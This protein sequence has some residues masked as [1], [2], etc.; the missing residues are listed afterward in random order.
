MPVIISDATG[1]IPKVMG[2]A[3]RLKKKFEGLRV[4]MASS[5]ESPAKMQHLMNIVFHQDYNELERE[6]FF[7]GNFMSVDDPKRE[8][9][10]PEAISNDWKYKNRR[11]SYLRIAQFLQV[12]PEMIVFID[13]DNFNRD[14]AKEAG[15]RVFDP[16]N[17]ENLEAA[18]TE[19]SANP[20][21]YDAGRVNRRIV[22]FTKPPSNHIAVLV[23]NQHT[24]DRQSVSDMIRDLASD[25][26]NADVRFYFT[27]ST[28]DNDIKP[29]LAA[30]LMEPEVFHDN[31]IVSGNMLSI[32]GTVT[33]ED[34]YGDPQSRIYPLN[35]NYK[36]N[37]D[38]RMDEEFYLHLSNQL[39]T[40]RIVLLDD[41]ADNLQAAA[42]AGFLG[43]DS[44]HPESLQPVIEALRNEDSRVYNYQ[45][46][47][48][49][50]QE[51]AKRRYKEQHPDMFTRMGR[52]MR[53][54]LGLNKREP[55]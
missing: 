36:A 29:D 12:A 53:N 6:G 5:A 20:V 14:P 46:V 27:T 13:D 4:F 15:L 17:L 44:G 33:E 24:Y 37:R 1:T 51:L 35:A 40:S 26:D 45:N 19:L 8:L 34:Y 54:V 10:Q 52:A 28:A 50:L 25:A 32:E 21:P 30:I 39:G 55:S 9:P 23:D 16:Q 47:N 38:F 22:R 43:I 42:K 18:V 31:A 11:K 41:N 48:I 49:R 3:A 2:P 7:A